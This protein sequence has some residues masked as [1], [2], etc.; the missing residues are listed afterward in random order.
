MVALQVISILFMAVGALLLVA[1]V[2]YFVQ[3]MKP[4][5]PPSRNVR[6]V[7]LSDLSGVDVPEPEPEE[8]ETPPTSQLNIPPNLT[9]S[10]LNYSPTSLSGMGGSWKPMSKLTSKRRRRFPP[11]TES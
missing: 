6:H 1:L 11:K 10:H 3:K 7:S 4:V 9:T 8:K 2:F 5:P